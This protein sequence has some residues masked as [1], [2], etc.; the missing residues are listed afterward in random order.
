MSATPPVTDAERERIRQLHAR[1][2]TCGQIAAE[3]GRNKSTITRQC[4]ALGLSFDRSQVKAAT[5]A[6]VADAKSRRA[7]AVR[8]LMDDFHRIRERAWSAYEVVMSSGTGV[9]TVLLD[10][11]P[12]QDTRAFYTAMSICIKDQVAIERHD[13]DEGGLSAVDAWLRGMLGEAV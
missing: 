5:E 9:E 2:L 7:E 13:A 3:L 12:A 11:P 6:K 4:R 10:R 8:V 1:G